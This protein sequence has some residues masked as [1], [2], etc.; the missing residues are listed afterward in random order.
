MRVIIILLL[1]VVLFLVAKQGSA[2]EPFNPTRE[3]PLYVS[4][5]LTPEECECVMS[6]RVA[7]LKIVK[8]AAELS[9]K[10]IENCEPPIILRNNSGGSRLMCATNDSCSEF[11]DL[12]GERIGCLVVYLNDNFS[13][14]ELLFDAHGGKKIKPEAGAGVFYRPLLNNRDVHKGEPVTMGTKY[15]CVVFVREN[16]SDKINVE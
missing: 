6:T 13:G 11:K 1:L 4:N 2:Y 3:P 14:G 16:H 10:P 9:G 15:T 5:I 8:L 7:P 12:G